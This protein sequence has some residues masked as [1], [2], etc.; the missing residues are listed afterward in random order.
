MATLNL[1]I[2]QGNTRIK[3][4]VF[5]GAELKSFVVIPQIQEISNWLT[6]NN[7]HIANSMWS[8]SASQSTPVELPGKLIILEANTPLPITI[9]YDSFESLGNDRKAN[10]CAAAAIFP[11]K[12]CLVIDA[13]TCIT[14]DL[15]R[16]DKTFV[17]GAISPGIEMRAKAMHQFTARLPEIKAPFENLTIGKSTHACLH[18]GVLHAA[19]LEAEGRIAELSQQ[20]E[21]LHV[22]LCGGDA[23][24]F[25]SGLKN[26]TFADSN[27]TLRGLNEI[28]QFLK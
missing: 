8:S 16:S 20:F 19:L 12:N 26:P 9:D 25:E 17:G 22:L 10:A 13:G 14:Y 23:S 27:L 24:Y 11:N 15:V 21:D 1:C 4:A 3:V 7:Y 5:E 28:L 2:D 6:T 18:S